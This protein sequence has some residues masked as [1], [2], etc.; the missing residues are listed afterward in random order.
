MK[1][2]YGAFLHDPSNPD[3]G[4]GLDYNFFSAFR[5]AGIDVVVCGPLRPSRL[6]VERA[7]RRGYKSVFKRR[8]L[9]WDIADIVRA[10]VLLNRMEK[11]VEPDV[12]FSIF[13]PPLAMYRGKA[14]CVFRT[15][16]TFRGWQEGGAGFGWLPLT[17]LSW[18]ERRAVRRS[19]RVLV[20]SEWC[21]T[22]IVK[23]HGISPERVLMHAA[24]CGL[25]EHVI[26]AG[27]TVER[28][29]IASPVRLLLVGRDWER[30]GVG[31]GIEVVRILNERGTAAT[32]TVCGVR[33]E[34]DEIVCFAGT[35]RKGEPREL[36]AYAGLYRNADL[37]I[38]PAFFDPSPTVPAEAAAFGVP[39]ITNDVGGVSTSVQHGRTGVVLPRHA[40]AESYVRVIEDLVNNE[41]RYRHLSRGARQRY[42]QEQNWRVTGEWAVAAL[43]EVA[44]AGRM[45][46]RA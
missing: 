17:I 11:V 35:F 6:V 9:K 22:E 31:I 34:S 15:D 2:L 21:K 8:Y 38:H 12:V 32:L 42:D 5:K 36:D 4:S 41:E 14:P 10:G 19:R 13:P 29:R 7:L 44:G 26:P 23:R 37:L 16:T 40:P 18:V 30:K 43:E 25:P 3:L 1:L 39:T 28:R 20:F 24:A 45:G 46:A 27:G 33:G